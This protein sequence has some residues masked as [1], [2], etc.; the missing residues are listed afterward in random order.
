MTTADPKAIAELLRRVNEATGP[1][2]EIDEAVRR[3]FDP[4]GRYFYSVNWAVT[5]STDAALALVERMLPGWH[6]TLNSCELYHDDD[7]E[8]FHAELDNYDVDTGDGPYYTAPLAI[9]SALLRALSP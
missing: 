2:R 7:L 4:N 6:W 3:T 1:D 8:R 5:S 9:L